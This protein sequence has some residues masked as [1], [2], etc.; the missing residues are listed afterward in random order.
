VAQE[1]H[2][3]Y[4]NCFKEKPKAAKHRDHPTVNLIANT[5]KVLA[6]ILRRRLERK[7]EDVLMKDQLG[8]RR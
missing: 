3:S 4:N 8:F 2:R 6:R 5:A 7:T 1:F